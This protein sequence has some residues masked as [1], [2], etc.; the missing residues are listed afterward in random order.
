[1]MLKYL[2]ILI[3]K[4]TRRYINAFVNRFVSQGNKS[5]YGV[6]A[7]IYDVVEVFIL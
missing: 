1:M 4:G 2:M 6:D 5:E 3:F 7:I